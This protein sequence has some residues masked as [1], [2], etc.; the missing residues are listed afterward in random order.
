MDKPTVVISAIFFI[1]IWSL[2][3]YFVIKE[4]IKYYKGEKNDKEDL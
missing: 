4:G 3:I 2:I 1:V